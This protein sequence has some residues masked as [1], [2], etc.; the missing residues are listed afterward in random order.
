MEGVEGGRGGGVKG[1][2]LVP[3]TKGGGRYGK[4]GGMDGVDGWKGG[5]G[6]G[7]EF[8]AYDEGRGRGPP[9]VTPGPPEIAFRTE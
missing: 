5:W 3:M 9:G 6:G 4:G 1:W 2:S 7:M 8:G